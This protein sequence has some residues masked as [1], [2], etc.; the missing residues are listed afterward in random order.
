MSE[1]SGAPY[2]LYRAFQHLTSRKIDCYNDVTYCNL[3]IQHH[4]YR[5]KKST[6]KLMDSARSTSFQE[7][8]DFFQSSRNLWEASEACQELKSTIASLSI[9][10]PIC[11]IIAF[12]CGSMTYFIPRDKRQSRRSTFQHALILTLK[13]ILDERRKTETNDGFVKE[14]N[15][16]EA[17]NIKCFAQD[18]DYSDIDRAVLEEHGITVLDDPRAFIEV[19]DSSVVFSCAADAPV[20]EIVSEIARPAMM[21]WDRVV[22]SDVHSKVLLYGR[23]RISIIVS[24]IFT[25]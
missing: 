21:I 19:D 3:A 17:G 2:V 24:T 15:D 18:P 14:G 22:E 16:N 9:H 25:L 10:H 5:R 7:M 6:K 1:Y 20:K 13:D 23:S 4:M 11:K 12:A 8:N